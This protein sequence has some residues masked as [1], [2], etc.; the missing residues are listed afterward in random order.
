[1]ASRT[2]VTSEN[3][4]VAP[5]RTS[6]SAAKPT[7]GLAVTPEK[8]SLPPHCRPTTRSEAGQ[9]SRRRWV[10]HLQPLL[11]HARMMAVDHG[12]EAVKASSCRRTMSRSARRRR[13]VAAAG[14]P[15]AA[16]RS[17]G[18]TTM[19][20]PPKFGLSARF[21][22]VRIGI[23]ARRRVDGDAAAVGVGERRPRR[24]RWGSAAAARP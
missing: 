19:T 5:A 2:S 8:A 17:R 22:S 15:A 6:R 3:I 24:R 18:P 11:G 4:T 16:S 12:A 10:E 14:A 9:V 23:T 13:V 1:M 7:A 21:C 20:S